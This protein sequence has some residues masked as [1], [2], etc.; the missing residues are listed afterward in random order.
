MQGTIFTHTTGKCI[1]K[2]DKF[3]REFLVKDGL[4]GSDVTM[5]QTYGIKVDNR[6]SRRKI[7][8]QRRDVLL[9]CGIEI[10]HGN[11][12]TALIAGL[13]GHDDGILEH[14]AGESG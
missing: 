11:P 7:H 9:G 14:L 3:L 13:S 5:P 1:G 6:R 4:G 10:V 8:I 12:H 2:A